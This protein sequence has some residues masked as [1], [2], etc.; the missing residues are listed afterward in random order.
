MS[1]T[2]NI[3]VTPS[4]LGEYISHGQCPRFAK[5]RSGDTD[6]ENA[7]DWKE[8]FSSLNPMLAEEG[9]RF[10]TGIYEDVRPLAHETIER[11][12]D[13]D[14]QPENNETLRNAV[15]D[16]ANR[17]PESDP[18]LLMQAH[19]AGTIGSFYV[20]GDADLIVIWPRADTHVDIRIFDIKASFNEKTYHQIQTACYT[21]LYEDVLTHDTVPD[22]LSWTIDAGIIHRESNWESLD[23]TTL[24]RFDPAPRE[25]DIRRLLQADGQLESVYQNDLE[26]ASY[27]LDAVCQSCPY[28]EACYAQS[29][30]ENDIRLLGLTRGEQ[31]AFRANGLETLADVAE[32]I[33][34]VDDPRPYQFDEPAIRPQHTDVAATLTENYAIGESLPTL[35][36]KA[37]AMLGEINPAHPDAH[38]SPWLPWVQGA[39]DGSLPD[40]DPRYEPDEMAIERGSLIRV[41]L[42]VQWDYLRDRIAVFSGRVACSNYDGTPLTFGEML[43]EDGVSD[44]PSVQAADEQRLLEAGFDRMFEAIRTVAML[45]GQSE[46]APVHLYFFDRGERDALMDGVKRHPSLAEANAVR[47]LLGLR[48]GIDQAMVSVVQEEV[49]SRLA[50]KEI[51]TGL[52]PLI[53]YFHP[54]TDEAF[55]FDDWTYTDSAGEEVDLRSVFYHAL[56]DYGVPF[57]HTG[58]SLLF[59]F[60]RSKSE[61]DGYYAARSRFGAEIPLEYIWA[62]QGI[63]EFDTSWTDD[64]KYQG[65]IDLYRW[66]DRDATNRITSEDIQTLS[67]KFTHA[68]NHVERGIAFRNADVHKEPLAMDDIDS[69]SL[70]DDS[71]A[72]ACKEYLDLEYATTSNDTKSLYQQPIRERILAGDSIAVEIENAEVNDGFMRATAHLIHDEFDFEDPASVSM[73]TSVKG[74]DDGGSGS[75]M[76]GT[77]LAP[78]TNGPEADVR[79]PSE[80]EHAAPCTVD[81]LDPRTGVVELTAFPNGGKK[82]HNYRTWHRGWTEDEDAGYETFIG[83]G[84]RLILDPQSDDMTAER[85]VTAL[86]NADNSALYTRLERM[87]EGTLDSPTTDTFDQDALDAYVEYCKT[88]AAPSPNSDQ[89]AFIGEGTAQISLLQGPPGTGKT[90]GA[91]SHA[92]LA[93][94]AAKNANSD[95]LRA[96][97]TGA[98]NKAVDELLEDVSATLVEY[99]QKQ[100][101]SGLDDVMLVRFVGETPANP[102]G[103]VTYINYH[104]DDAKMARLE[105]RLNPSGDSKQ[106]TFGDDPTGEPHVIVFTTPS[107]VEGFMDKHS[108]FGTN[109]PFEMGPELFDCFAMDEAS[110]LSLPQFLLAG[111]FITKEAQVLVGGDQRQMPPVQKHDWPSEDR[112]T[113]EQAAPHLSTLDFFR[114]LRGDSLEAVDDE[115]VASAPDADIP[116][117][118]LQETYRCHSTVAEFL[119]RWVYAQDDIEY[120]SA[121]TE[122]IPATDGPTAGITEV[123]RADRPLTLVLHDDTSSQQSNVVEA[124]LSE[125]L[126]D[127]LPKTESLGI[128]T[129]HNAQKGLL[130]SMCGPDAHVDTVER[131][132]GG[133]RDVMVMSATVSDPDY[134]SAEAD[135]LLNPNRLNVALSR[136]KKK[137]LVI[138][139]KNLF[140]VLPSD[141]EEYNDATIWKGLYQAVDADGPAD[142][143]GTLAEFTGEDGPDG[144]TN[145]W[146]HGK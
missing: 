44:D 46:E 4:E 35:A 113:I 66:R 5:L 21:I 9:R 77:P 105:S 38:D 130:A 98:S 34:P 142:W 129:P 111:A 136:M 59:D 100:D 114:L 110:M 37:Q 146:V 73:A 133:Q 95:H 64:P 70:G 58:D 102:L 3:V 28:N 101:D 69:F 112:R 31:Q 108:V 71:L 1:Q 115:V 41:Y 143:A 116:L 127:A 86:E 139:P 47:D 144:A 13:Y 24:P 75:W 94:A 14:A 85:A 88:D 126:V 53:E 121:R 103:N 125:A 8:A 90:S 52:V 122:T 39:G 45:S 128:V 62:A 32:L 61:Y 7:R 60:D 57:D 109:N 27:Q 74:G 93:R 6:E 11:W 72:T 134:Q 106:T 65:I 135:F 68:L 91:L 81:R 89:R 48:A 104:E 63:D 10:E 67:E 120:Q 123:I 84:Q 117:A 107:R 50:T 83:E 20:P 54:S 55:E 12:R 76:L 78:G 26:D 92:V 124:K 29:V 118:R 15:I 43:T 82:A 25:A 132:Q 96:I 137:L 97:V 16:A 18:T 145:V 140:N 42:N 49:E 22:A 119:R 2:D 51:A 17:G 40:D 138:A 99:N 56:F 23:D 80:I 87:L 141:I 36:Q 19:L 79:S 30:E 131:F 33:E